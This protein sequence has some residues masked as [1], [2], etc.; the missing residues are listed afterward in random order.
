MPQQ[1]LCRLSRWRLPQSS[2]YTADRLG[3][4]RI[5]IGIIREH[6]AGWIGTSRVPL[7]SPP[8]STAVALS[9]AAIGASL[10]TLD[11]HRTVSS[12]GHQRRVGDR[13]GED[14]L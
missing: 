3:I 1:C 10:E 9:A 7:A 8:A 6:V 2:R 4:A 14:I 11:R 5:N 13:I 12:A